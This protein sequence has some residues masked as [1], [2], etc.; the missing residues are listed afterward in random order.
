MGRPIPPLHRILLVI[1]VVFAFAGCSELEVGILDDGIVDN[2][3]PDPDPGTDPLP[4]G[5]V[6]T[7]RPPPASVSFTPPCPLGDV[8][9]GADNPNVT[10]GCPITDCIPAVDDPEWGTIGQVASKMLE[11]ERVMVIERDGMVRGIPIK[12]LIHHEVVN[13]CWKHDDG[14]ES[15]SM[16]SYCPIVDVAVHFDRDFPCGLTRRFSYGVSSGIYNGNLIV[17]QR[18]TAGTTDGIFV[19]MYGGGLNSDCLDI[20]PVNLDMTWGMFRR[21]Y[22]K[23]EVLTE[24]TGN[25]PVGGYDIFAHPYKEF[26]A[27]PDLCVNGLC[28]PV[29]STDDR[30]R[31]KEVVFGLYTPSRTKVYPLKLFRTRRVVNDRVGGK[32]IVVWHHQNAVA[33]FE[34]QVGEMEL[35]FNF[36]SKDKRDLPLFKDRETE[37]IWTFDGICVQ[38]ELEGVRLAPVVGYRSFW[39]AWAAF[40]PG[41]IIKG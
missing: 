22:P 19:Q 34:A 3:D 26:W 5:F 8:Q 13:V 18:G 39:F 17:Y 30:L 35:R 11:F 7:D 29:S 1:G 37:S 31:L 15:Y 38:G 36:L 25:Q 21:L 28:F 4:D 41:S 12:I 14:S 16:V 32:K 10:L 23:A 6:D 20:E 33:A 40:F 27:S 9:G 24:N 2:E